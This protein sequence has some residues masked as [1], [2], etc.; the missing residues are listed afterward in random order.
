[1]HLMPVTKRSQLLEINGGVDLHPR[2][3]LNKGFDND[4]SYRITSYNVCY[5]KLLRDGFE[6]ICRR[7]SSKDRN[8]SFTVAAKE[9]LHEIGLLRF[10]RKAGA[11]STALNIHAD[12]RKLDHD[13]ESKCLGLQG[14]SRP[15]RGRCR[16][17][18]ITSYN[19][20]YT[21]LLRDVFPYSPAWI[22]SCLPI[23]TVR[24]S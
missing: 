7:R 5:T 3:S 10:C 6:T 2:R 22:L 8:R 14:D 20:C 16:E 24:R 15:A 21:K 17:C 11:W 9:S 1:M 13:G 19:V 12:E 4:G 23:L 18:R